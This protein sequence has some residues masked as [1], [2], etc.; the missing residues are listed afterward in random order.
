M[1][2]SWPS[3]P[4]ELSSDSYNG[5]VFWDME[6]WMYPALLAQHPDVAKATDTYLLT[7]E[8]PKNGKLCR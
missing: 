1:F 6:T 4:G 3:P 7:T 2:V 8:P 5:H